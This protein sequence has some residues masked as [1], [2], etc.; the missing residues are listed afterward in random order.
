M[1]FSAVLQAVKKGPNA[2]GGLLWKTHAFWKVSKTRKRN[3]LKKLQ[4]LNANKEVLREA[5]ALELQHAAVPR[6]PPAPTA[7]PTSW[8]KRLRDMTM[9]NAELP[10]IAGSK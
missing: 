4:I 1:F 8:P 2:R 5:A 7:P 10:G 6:T 3:V 9:R